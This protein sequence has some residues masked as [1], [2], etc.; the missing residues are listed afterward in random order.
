MLTFTG[1]LYVKVNEKAV[2]MS[3]YNR[4]TRREIAFELSD[5]GWI[6]DEIAMALGIAQATV[7]M[8]LSAVRDSKY[9]KTDS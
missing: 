9:G 5:L 4:D 7:S 3:V 8:W 6:Q 2:E 1:V